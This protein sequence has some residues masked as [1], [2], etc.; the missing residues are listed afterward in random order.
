[1]STTAV[2]QDGLP[3]SPVKGYVQSSASMLPAIAVGDWLLVDGSEHP[4]VG[5]VVL[6]SPPIQPNGTRSEPVLKRIIARGRDRLAMRNG[7]VRV[8]GRALQ[9]TQCVPPESPV[10]LQSVEVAVECVVERS[11]SG[12]EYRVIRNRGGAAGD[13]DELQVPP[14]HFFVL[15]DFRDHSIDSRQQGA[16]P[17]TSVMGVAKR[18]YNSPD[19]SRIGRRL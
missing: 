9:Q 19:R 18:I 7:A 13:F 16:I 6:Y 17:A 5:D 2:A 4:A 12:K 10:K 3:G 8:N 14:G 15:G 11:E 1:M